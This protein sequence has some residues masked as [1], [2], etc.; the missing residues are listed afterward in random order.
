[1]CVVIDA[2][3]FSEVTDDE[4]TDF[5]PLRKWIQ[6]ERHRVVHGGSEYARHLAKHGKFAAYLAELGRGGN[7]PLRLDGNEVD[8][9]EAFLKQEFASARY[10]DHHIAALLFVSGCRVVAS[11]DRGFHRLIQQCSVKGRRTI[12]RHMPHLMVTRSKVYQYA[13]HGAI[14]KS[15]S[16]RRCC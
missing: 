15:R 1:M 16:V 12:L 13:R 3:V 8:E 6:E 4:N 9:T 2:D 14:L 11:H 7:P 10:D 5:E